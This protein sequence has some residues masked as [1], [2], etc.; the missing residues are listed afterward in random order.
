MSDTF[1]LFFLPYVP[2]SS[3]ETFTTDLDLYLYRRT[4]IQR[5]GPTYL[6]TR[7]VR[8]RQDAAD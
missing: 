5:E 8:Y 3:M 7:P 1:Y 4:T 2:F 6:P